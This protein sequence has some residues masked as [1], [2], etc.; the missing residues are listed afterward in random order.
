MMMTLI[1]S[2]RAKTSLK[3][4]AVL[5]GEGGCANPLCLPRLCRLLL[6]SAQPH[7]D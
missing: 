5:S 6:Q 7:W 3:M 1:R 4:Q 2:R